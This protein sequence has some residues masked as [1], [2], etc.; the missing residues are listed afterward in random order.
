MEYFKKQ[1]VSQHLASIDQVVWDEVQT[2]MTS[3]KQALQQRPKVTADSLMTGIH[4][5]SE[6]NRLS[7]S[8]SQK[9]FKLFSYYLS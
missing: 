7:P 8:Q 3:N 5:D 2:K 6:G 1:Y 9:Q 4:F